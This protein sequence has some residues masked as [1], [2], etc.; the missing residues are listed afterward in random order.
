MGMSISE[1]P[2]EVESSKTFDHLELDTIV[3]IRG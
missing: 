3:S 2:K 1:R